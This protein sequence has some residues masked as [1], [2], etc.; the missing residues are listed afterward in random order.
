MSV[1]QIQGLQ[2]HIVELCRGVKHGILMLAY[3]K[4]EIED[5]IFSETG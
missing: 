2:Q 3:L 4:R 5:S 1:D